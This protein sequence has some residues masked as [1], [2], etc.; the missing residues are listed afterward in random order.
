[1]LRVNVC[2]SCALSTP[3][4]PRAVVDS[5][6]LSEYGRANDAYST[7]MAYTPQPRRGQH[8]QPA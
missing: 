2:G 1:M 4:T 5:E 8:R 6:D 3:I 7:V